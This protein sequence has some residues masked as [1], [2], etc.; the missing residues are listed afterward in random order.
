MFINNFDPVAFTILSFEIRWYS[1]AYIF[2]ILIGWYLSKKFFIDNDKLKE[3]FDDYITYVIIGIILGGRLGYVFFYDFSYFLNN[4]VEI[5]QIWNGGMSFHGGL[6]GVILASLLFSKSKNL[7]VFE[8]LDVIAIVT[9]IG[10]FLGRIAN[11]INSEL[12]GKAT[13]VIWSVKFVKVDEIY[14]HPSQLYEAFLEGIVLFVILI[15]VKKRSKCLNPGY[16]SGIFLIF[17]SIFRFI[18]EFYRVPDEQIGYLLLNL[19]LGQYISIIF[20]AIGITIFSFKN[21]KK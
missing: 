5:F 15:F 19:T 2:G 1:L 18:C 6:L 17:Y 8:F 14:R 12:Y 16:I 20:L 4:P 13:E 9:P 10:L 7:D 3:V 21:E 11:F